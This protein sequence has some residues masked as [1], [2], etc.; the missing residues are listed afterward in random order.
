[1]S[2]H[3]SRRVAILCWYRKRQT[4]D[5]VLTERPA[6]R[7]RAC[8]TYRCLAPDSLVETVVA[9]SIL[10]K[11]IVVL[12]LAKAFFAG[13]TAAAVRL[14]LSKLNDIRAVFHPS[15]HVAHQEESTS[16]NHRF[17]IVQK[18]KGLR[19]QCLQNRLIVPMYCGIFIWLEPYFIQFFETLSKTLVV[20]RG[21]SQHHS[22]LRILLHYCEFPCCPQIS[23]NETQVRSGTGKM[24]F[25]SNGSGSARTTTSCESQ[26]KT[27]PRREPVII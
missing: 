8:Q 14:I 25:F 23:R 15:Q 2:S 4:S 22:F 16:C 19:R 20:D 3:K 12:A 13:C 10:H 11:P 18:K 5:F 17:T 9:R 21:I 1:M 6:T 26:R 7:V 24:M 27:F